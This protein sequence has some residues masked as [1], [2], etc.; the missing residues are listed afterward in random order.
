VVELEN[1]V[2][3]G[4]VVECVGSCMVVE[5]VDSCM[6]VKMGMMRV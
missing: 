5:C 4:M 1:V 2:V 3:T 6:V